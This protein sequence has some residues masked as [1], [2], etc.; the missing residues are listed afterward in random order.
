MKQHH[1]NYF[2]KP[3]FDEGDDLDTVEIN[4]L[5]YFDDEIWIGTVDGYLMLYNVIPNKNCTLRRTSLSDGDLRKPRP[6]SKKPSCS[7]EVSFSLHKYPPGKRLQPD[8]NV[9]IAIPVHRQHMYYIPTEKEAQVEEKTS[10]QEHTATEM[11]K[12]KISVVINQNT[13]QYS[14]EFLTFIQPQYVYI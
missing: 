3:S 11:E 5:L 13:K 6:I 14:G 1:I 2:R 9:P 12:R 7:N 4:T 8:N 10:L